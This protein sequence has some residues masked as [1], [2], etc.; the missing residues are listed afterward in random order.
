MRRTRLGMAEVEA[1]RQR[2]PFA[3]QLVQ[4]PPRLS[5]ARHIAAS[6][7]AASAVGSGDTGPWLFNVM[8]DPTERTNLVTSTPDKAAE[9]KAA[10]DAA[11]QQT[12]YPFNCKGEPGATKVP[13]N[14]T[15]PGNVWTPWA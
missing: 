6:K 14:I 13:I 5:L 9:L 4:E 2:D 7:R 12:R 8:A 3:L 1:F 15:C 11:A 10:L